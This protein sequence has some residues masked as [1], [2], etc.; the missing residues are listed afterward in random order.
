MTDFAI[1][2]YR[3]QRCFWENSIDEG[4]A[5]DIDIEKIDIKIWK[6]NRRS[7]LKFFVN[8]DQISAFKILLTAS[9]KQFRTRVNW[10]VLFEPSRCIL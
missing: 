10:K 3:V 8:I 9:G 6:K 5:F 4:I 1:F 2:I 7:K